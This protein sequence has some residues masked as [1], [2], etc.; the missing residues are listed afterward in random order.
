MLRTL[1]ARMEKKVKDWKSKILSQ[2]R[3]LV[4]IKSV[5]QSILTYLISYFKIPQ[6]VLDKIPINDYEI[7]VGP[8]E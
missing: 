7:L 5:A 1:V 3:K 2:A 8:K 6:G 4:L